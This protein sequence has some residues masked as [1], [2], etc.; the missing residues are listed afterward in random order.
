MSDRIEQQASRGASALFQAIRDTLEVVQGIE[1]RLAVL[2][3]R[4]AEI[5]NGK[6]EPRFAMPDTTPAAS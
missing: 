4:V 1:K 3:R 2:E 5:Q 6:G